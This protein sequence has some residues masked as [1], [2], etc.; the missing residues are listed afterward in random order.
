MGND[1][2]NRK[3]PDGTVIQVQSVLFVKF[4]NQSM[5]GVDLH[6]QMPGYYAIG[7]RSRKWWWYLFWF[8]VK[9]DKSLIKVAAQVSSGTIKVIVTIG[10][11][12][13]QGRTASAGQL[14]VGHWPVALM[15]GRCKYCLKQKTTF[16][17]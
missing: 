15:K 5:G 16:S 13:S 14:E 1:K 4:Y 17:G 12:C 2:V 10:D 6:E 11:F 3:Q 9:R 7:R 8:C